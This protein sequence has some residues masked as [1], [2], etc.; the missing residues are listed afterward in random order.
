MC[1]QD[2]LQLERA[3]EDENSTSGRQKLLKRIYHLKLEHE[4]TASE[5]VH[6][7]P[8]RSSAAPVR[9]TFVPGKLQKSN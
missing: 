9:R 6:N 5:E 8:A 1:D 3:L 2:F 4:G 7:K